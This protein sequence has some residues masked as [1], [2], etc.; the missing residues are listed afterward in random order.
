MYPHMISQAEVLG[1]RVVVQHIPLGGLLEWDLN[2]TPSGLPATSTALDANIVTR[3]P[4]SPPPPV[5][6]HQVNINTS[7]LNVIPSLLDHRGPTST[8]R[9]ASPQG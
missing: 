7:A 5:A 1:K 8:G 4:S 3:A 2:R 6:L 9:R